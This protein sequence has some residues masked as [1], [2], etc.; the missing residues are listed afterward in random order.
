MVWILVS[1]PGE[2]DAVDEYYTG[3]GWNADASLSET[4]TEIEGND[5][6]SL[7]IAKGQLQSQFPDRDVRIA[8]ATVTIAVGTLLG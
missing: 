7:R 4:Y 2:A 6:Q 3:A 1:A 8:E 5:I